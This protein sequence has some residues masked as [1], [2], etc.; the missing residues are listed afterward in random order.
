MS[1]SEV[2]RLELFEPLKLFGL[3]SSLVFI[4]LSWAL[5]SLLKSSQAW[6]RFGTCSIRY[7]AYLLRAFLQARAFEPS[8]VP[9]QLKV[10]ERLFPLSISKTKLLQHLN[11]NSTVQAFHWNW[12]G[13]VAIETWKCKNAKV[14]VI[15]FFPRYWS[16]A[17]Q[18]VRIKEVRMKKVLI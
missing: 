14:A 2:I 18:K 3:Y 1:V 7:R 12:K 17:L 10:G 13:S 15:S 11:E 5:S 6:L 4:T 9:F 16:G 8:R